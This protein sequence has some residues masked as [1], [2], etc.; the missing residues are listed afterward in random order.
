MRLGVLATHPIQYHAPLH[1][2]LAER[3]D[4]EVF[5]AHEQTAEGQARAGFGVAFEWDVPL[6]EGY[7]HR[8]LENVAAEPDPST[9]R[10]CNT[11]EIAG[12][13]A[14]ERFDAF[15]VNGWYNQSYW[16]AIRACWRTGTPV[17]IRGDSQLRTPRSWPKRMAKQVAYRAFIP[18]FDAYLVVG[19]R[20]REYYLHYGAKEERMHFVPHFVDNDFF[21]TRADAVDREAFRAE[22]GIAEDAHVLL[23]VGKFIPKK[24]P[25]HV[26]AAAEM[27]H[28]RGIDVEVMLVGS[29]P[30]EEELRAQ[31]QGIEAPVHFA[32]FRNQSELP[33]HY[34]SAD[35]LVLPS[36]GD[37][38]WGLVVNEAMACGIPAVVSD[39]VGCGPDLIDP[40]VTGLVYPEGNVE[41]LADAV[42]R[43]YREADP[44]E[45][46]QALA[47]KMQVY[48]LETAVEGV[49]EAMAQPTWV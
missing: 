17:L 1:R 9:L 21:R 5:F 20:A 48:S 22:M 19:Q 40:G 43:F 15:L 45:V 42:E 7:R 11:P 13:I 6:L 49:L 8:F 18:R 41:A 30:L 29:G 27:L 26:L 23:F 46:R 33:A 3:L 10:G 34:A 25:G 16:Q 37:E 28:A 39:A 44:P 14:R 36:D 31:A 2:A 38:T 32:G 24:R 12:I 47:E 4:L 35:L